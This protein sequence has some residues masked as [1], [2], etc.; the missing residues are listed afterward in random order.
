MFFFRNQILTNGLD[1]IFNI[2]QFRYME[3]SSRS[4]IELFMYLFIY[5]PMI[6]WK[7][8]NALIVTLIAVIIPRFFDNENSLKKNILSSICVFLFFIPVFSAMG[9]GAIAVSLNYLWP[10]FFFVAH[11]YL[12]K[13]Y[14]FN[15]TELK[16]WKKSNGLFCF[17]F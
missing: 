17:S 7:V 6:V 8:L 2:L 15:K 11:F 12:L 9:A 10:L 1:Q 13:R 14:I 4:L 16:L 5:L 3:W